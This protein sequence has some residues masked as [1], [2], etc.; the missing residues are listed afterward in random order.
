MISLLSSKKKE[1][2]GLKM[3]ERQK[4]CGPWCM[5]PKSDLDGMDGTVP[6]ANKAQRKCVSDDSQL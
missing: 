3:F 6:S 5:H 2:F 4:I 1:H